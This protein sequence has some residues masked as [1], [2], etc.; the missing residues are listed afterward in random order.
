MKTVTVVFRRTHFIVDVNEDGT[1]DTIEYAHNM[2]SVYKLF[3]D[4]GFVDDIQTLTLEAIS[5]QEQEIAE[6]IKET[7]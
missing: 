3:F 6:Q 7:L 5:E 2:E 1:V 4:M